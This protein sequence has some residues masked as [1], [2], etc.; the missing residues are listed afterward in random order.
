MTATAR[1]FALAGLALAICVAGVVQAGEPIPGVDIKLGKNWGGAL[2]VPIAT[3][4]PD[5]RFSTRARVE[6]GEYVVSTACSPRRACPSIRLLTLSVNDR[7]IR[8][9]ARGR[10]LFPVG[11]DQNTVTLRGRVETAGPAAAPR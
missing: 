9:D 10:Y 6:R 1:L 7:P 11:A 8:P 4:G 5:G 3:T 2:A